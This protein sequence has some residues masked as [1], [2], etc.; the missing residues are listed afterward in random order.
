MTAIADKWRTQPMYSFVEASRL[1]NVSTTTVKNWF[2][3][4][5]TKAKGDVPPLFPGGVAGGSMLSYLQLMETVVAARFRMVDNARYRDVHAAYRNAAEILKV[6]YPFA[7]LKLE[8]L[9]GHIIARLEGEEIGDSL[10]AFDNPVQWSLPGLIIDTILQV[11]YEDELAAKWFPLGKEYPIVID[12]RISSGIPTIKGRGI[13]VNAVFKRWRAGN[14]IG[15]IAEDL[16]MEADVV[17][18]VLQYGDGIA[19]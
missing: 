17:E 13:S 12:P 18:T 16:E 14:K 3:G 1:A 2:L 15:F 11:D 8:S 19:A 10:Q 9:G 6:E 4:C 7:H 5:S